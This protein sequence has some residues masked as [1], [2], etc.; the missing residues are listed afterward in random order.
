MKI[1]SAVLA[2]TGW[3]LSRDSTQEIDV[4]ESYSGPDEEARSD[5]FA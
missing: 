2:A 4:L 3:V 5:W 1:P